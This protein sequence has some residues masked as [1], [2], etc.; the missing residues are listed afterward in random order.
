MVYLFQITTE[1]RNLFLTCLLK[2]GSHYSVNLLQP[3]I[4]SC[5][6]EIFFAVQSNSLTHCNSRSD[7]RLVWTSLNLRFQVRNFENSVPQMSENKFFPITSLFGVRHIYTSPLIL[8][9]WWA[10]R[11]CNWYKMYRVL[12]QK[13]F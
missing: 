4:D 6:Y 3:V 12:R 11:F 8:Q 10:V 5:G 1:N 9:F 7:L 2:A 13:N